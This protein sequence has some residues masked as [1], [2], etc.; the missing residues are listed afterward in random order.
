MARSWLQDVEMSTVIVLTKGDT[1]FK[2]L[3]R[4]VHDDC[5]VLHQ[6][7]VLQEEPVGG[8]TTAMIDGDLVIPREQVLGIQLITVAEAAA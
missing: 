3:K 1:S 2:G 5:I 8:H 6:A 7:M 4:A